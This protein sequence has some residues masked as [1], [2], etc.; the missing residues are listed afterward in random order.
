MVHNIRFIVVDDR[1]VVLGVP[2]STGE[3]EATRKGYSIPSEGLATILKEHFNQCADKVNFVDYLKEV[4]NQTGVAP[5]HLA[6]ELQIDI[7]ELERLV[8]L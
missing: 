8:R 6:Q 5:R 4:I 1:T 3:K 2:E 7:E